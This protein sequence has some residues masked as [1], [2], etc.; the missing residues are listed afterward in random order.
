MLM[1]G[2]PA[3]ALGAS[4]PSTNA[5]TSPAMAIRCRM[6]CCPP[7]DVARES[8]PS[9]WARRYLVRN[10]A[11]LREWEPLT[12]WPPA[13]SPAA[14]VKVAVIGTTS[15]CLRFNVRRPAFVSDTRALRVPAVTLKLRLAIPLPLRR[16]RP[17]AGLRTVTTAVRR[18]TF[19]ATI[20]TLQPATPTTDLSS[21][22]APFWP[23]IDEL[24]ESGCVQRSAAA[25]RAD[26]GPA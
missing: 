3:E 20:F 16:I 10:A 22:F 25:D 4:T 17:L 2:V 13:L 15:L 1:N 7:Q 19:A 23:T 9:V 12:G 5:E 18:R 21:C 14:G 11:R 24:T 8:R 6:F 26:P